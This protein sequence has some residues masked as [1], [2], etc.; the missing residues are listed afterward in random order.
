MDAIAENINNGRL[1]YY[2][3]NSTCD[4]VHGFTAAD[5]P[6]TSTVLSLDGRQDAYFNITA[7]DENGEQYSTIN[8]IFRIK[9]GGM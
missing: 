8:E 5:T 6:D 9:S 7:F 4:L 2:I 3:Y 1:R